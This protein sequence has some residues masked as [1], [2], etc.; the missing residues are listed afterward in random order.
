MRGGIDLGN[1]RYSSRVVGAVDIRRISEPERGPYLPRVRRN[2]PLLVGEP[3]IILLGWGGA[4][5]LEPISNFGQRGRGF[6]TVRG[7]DDRRE[8]GFIP[9]FVLLL[10]IHTYN[11][12]W[13]GDGTLSSPGGAGSIIYDPQPI[14]DRPV[15][16]VGDFH[17]VRGD[18]NS[19][20]IHPFLFPGCQGCI[21]VD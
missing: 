6:H 20:D 18:I 9:R 2:C 1:H 10:D 21:C 4:V 15:G 16:G 17:A 7:G 14:R 11:D 3:L 19:G 12:L 5:E 8:I 13:T